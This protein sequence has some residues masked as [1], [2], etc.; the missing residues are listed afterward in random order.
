M[1]RL[2]HHVH[3]INTYTFTSHS[4]YKYSFTLYSLYKYSFTLH[5]LWFFDTSLLAGP[6][7]KG[8]FSVKAV[9]TQCR[10]MLVREVRRRGW[11]VGWGE[12][13]AL[14]CG[15]AKDSSTCACGSQSQ[16]RLPGYQTLPWIRLCQQGAWGDRW[17]RCVLPPYGAWKHQHAKAEPRWPKSSSRM[18]S[19]RD[20]KVIRNSTVTKHRYS[21]DNLVKHR[22]CSW[23]PDYLSQ[24]FN[25]ATAK[26]SSTF[27]SIHNATWAW[28]P[29]TL[30]MAIQL[31]LQHWQHWSEHW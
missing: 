5:K 31:L 20:R 22:L 24:P 26:W 25:N 19:T 15:Q 8:H 6:A 4:P 16:N 27:Y 30:V 3:L 18:A 12:V 13:V 23:W 21:A 9:C 17:W 7:E 1:Q 14:P 2:L 28:L 11:G 29:L 10:S